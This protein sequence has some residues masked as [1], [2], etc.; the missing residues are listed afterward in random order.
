M[1]G[2]DIL[3]GGA[4]ADRVGGGFGDDRMYIDSAADGVFESANQ[5]YYETDNGN[6]FYDSN[7]SAASGS[8]LIATLNPNLTLTHADFL[9]I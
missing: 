5:G 8:T 9:L 3:N 6:L 1:G 7:G 2:N 4:G